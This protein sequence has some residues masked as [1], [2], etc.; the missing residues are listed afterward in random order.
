MPLLEMFSGIARE[1][2][3]AILFDYRFLPVYVVIILIAKTKYD[4]HM[5]FQSNIYGQ[6]R[7]TI[8]Q[9]MEET[10]LYGLVAG[11]FGSMLIVSMGITLNEQVFSYLFIILIVL[12]VINTRFASF[13]YA[14]GILSVIGLLFNIEGIDVTSLLA[15]AAIM[16]FIESLLI[17]ISAGRNSIP[18]FIKHK[19]GIAGAFLIQRFWLIPIVFL[20]TILPAAE[21][22]AANPVSYSGPA[23]FKP[24]L[25]IQGLAALGLDCVIGILAYSDIAITKSPE[26][27]SRETAVYTLCYSIVLFVIALLSKHIFALQLLGALFCIAAREGIVLY[28]QYTEKSGT[29]MFESV[30]RGLRVF[31]ILPGS[32][33]EKMGMV[34][35]D[36]ILNVNGK[37]VQTEEGLNEAL[38]DFPRFVWI[39]VLGAHGHEK[40]YEY[41]DYPEGVNYLGI[42]TVPREKEVTYNIDHFERLVILKNLVARFR[43]VNRHL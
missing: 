9:I 1:L 35:G 30:R 18:V 26:K 14:A 4:K 15:L 39:T 32:P 7:I 34:R 41:K 20:T 28:G 21:A 8:R 2:L 27:R 40:T 36:I 37:D 22:S 38:K 6:V 5:D 16:H 13:A 29:P 17:F 31:E 12:A 33:A 23:W 24:E 10:V 25:L 43:G 11:F 19:Q 42:L 3:G